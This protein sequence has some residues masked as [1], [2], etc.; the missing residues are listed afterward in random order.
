ML[1][2]NIVEGIKFDSKNVA[3][4]SDKKEEYEDIPI[5]VFKKRVSA[6]DIHKKLEILAPDNSHALIIAPQ[7]EKDALALMVKFKMDGRFIKYN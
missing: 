3:L 4:Y 7:F 6:M 1:E 2:S 5:I